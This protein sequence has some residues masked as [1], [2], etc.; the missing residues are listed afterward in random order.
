MTIGILIG[1]GFAAFIAF[2]LFLQGYGS[3]ACIITL[4]VMA[5]ILCPL[6]GLIGHWIDAI[7]KINNTIKATI[8]ANYDNVVNFHNGVTDESFVSN[9]SKYTFDYDEETKTLKI[10]RAHV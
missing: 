1:L 2:G 6:L 3:E 9:G 10:G 5:L 4:L 7:E 8:N